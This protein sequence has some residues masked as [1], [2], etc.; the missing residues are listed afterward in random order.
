MVGEN[1]ARDAAR[2]D[3]GAKGSRERRFGQSHGRPSFKGDGQ[4]RGFK[5][6]GQSRGFKGDGQ[7][8]GF[9]GDGQSRGF[10]RDGQ[11]DFRREERRET[12]VGPEIPE[13]YSEDELAFGVRAELRGLSKER[14][15]QVAKHIWAAG[16]L[17]DAD[18]ELAFEHANTARKLAP[19][20][21][22]VREATA[23]TAYAAGKFEVA[24]REYRA[25]RRI[26]GGDE[27][28]PVIADCERAVGRPR[29]ALET[30]AQLVQN[31]V[32]PAVV[33]EAVIVEAGARDDL[34]QRAEGLRLLKRLIGRGVGPTFARARLYY[35]YADLLLAEGAEDDA[36][37][38]FVEAANLD[39]AGELDTSD[40]I[41]ELDGVTLP[42]SMSLEEPDIAEPEV[43]QESK[44][45]AEVGSEDS[46]E[47]E[48]V[49]HEHAAKEEE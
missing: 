32:P 19:R 11:R 2:G 10:K 42:E 39:R 18:P 25:I 47:T 36:R 16:Q 9:K 6:D 5:G 22:I 41:A 4:S 43:A 33:L 34:G 3:G 13:G 24:L 17:I 15:D 38:A 35:A 27:L 12:I 30:L 8:R 20:L 14:S 31:S 21:A 23:E 49:A 46:T 29:E 26:T 40:R 7:S 1:S 37:A 45:A 44:P 28:I 48:G